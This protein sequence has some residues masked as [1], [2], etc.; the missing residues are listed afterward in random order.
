MIK[1]LKG[2]TVLSLLT[3]TSCMDHDLTKLSSEIYAEFAIATPLIHSTTTLRDLLPENEN[4]STDEDSLIR[5]TFRQDSIAQIESDS[6]LVIEN[7]EPT[8]QEFTVGAIELPDFNT[9][10]SVV[11]SDLTSN[12]EDLTL[13]D[14]IAE[15]IDF[16]QVYGSAYFPPID[17]QYGGSYST[18]GSNEFNSVLISEGELT[19]EISNNLAIDLNELSLRLSNSID[20]SEIGV[21]EFS[22]VQASTASSSSITMEG[23]FL[24]SDLK[25]EIINLSSPGTGSNPLDQTSWV[26][27]S[28]DDELI[29]AVNGI[30]LVAT[31]GMVKFPAQIGPDSTF[32]VD[33]DFEDGAVIDFI[34]LSAGQF[35]YSFDSDLNTT[36]EL[37]LEIPQLLDENGNSFSEVIEIV[38]SGLVTDSI[39]LENYK[40][41][42]SSSINQLQ[43]NYSSQILA[44]QDFVSFDEANQI[45][46]SIGMNNLEFDLIQ[47]YFGQLEETIAEDILDL[48]LSALAE[49]ASGMTLES[50][51]L[52][53]TTD[54]SIGIPFEIDILLIAE[55]DGEIVS[56]NG[57]VL[58]IASEQISTT[59]FNSSNSQLS[60]LIAI[61][62]TTITYSG[63]VTSNPL[64]NIGIPNTLRPNTGITLGFEM[65]LPLHLRIQD[66]V[67]RDTL[68]LAF[69]SELSID[70]IQSVKMKLHTQNEFPLDVDLTMFF[71]DSISGIVL[72][73]LQ[74]ELLQAAEVDENGKTI[75]ARVY[76]SNI[77]LN[78]EQFDALFNSNRTILDIRMNSYD[79]ENSAIKLYTDY[80]FIIAAGVIIELK[81]EE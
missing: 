3:F 80:E 53:F 68:A 70:M 45:S 59:S 13:S 69:D 32:V 17:P 18:Q 42:F 64:G 4:I 9:N 23:V 12:L 2:L 11:M 51:S 33:M 66:A 15:A 1:S 76:D 39:S 71:Q 65:D 7:Q 43:V 63:S 8:L 38:N 79:S 5:I 44:T 36:L 28:N 16:S 48:D 50:P 6:L 24:Y 37:I 19:I 73:S 20:N 61:N 55:T 56:L 10:I 60:E 52:I 72:D 22:N 57:P 31:E 35:L 30:N 25:M 58:E 14:Q 41:D 40:F 74:V 29:I 67:T 26:P 27:I 49:I 62:P 46:L 81:I 21:F 77:S 54:N 34:N 75:E 78:S 47:G